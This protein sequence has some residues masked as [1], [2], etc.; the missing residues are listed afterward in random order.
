M[1]ETE[2]KHKVIAILSDLCNL[3]SYYD[4]HAYPSPRPLTWNRRLY[5]LSYGYHTLYEEEVK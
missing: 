2:N 3:K 5:I 4:P 1:R